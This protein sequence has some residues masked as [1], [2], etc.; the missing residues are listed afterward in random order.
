MNM[1]FRRSLIMVSFFVVGIALVWLPYRIHIAGD[2]ADL[3][4]VMLGILLPL[5]VFA[6]AASIALTAPV[7]ARDQGV[8]PLHSA[9]VRRVPR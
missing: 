4:S 7:R 6:I 9:Q 1:T 3:R 2:A 5:C 8:T